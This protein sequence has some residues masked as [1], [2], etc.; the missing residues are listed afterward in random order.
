[1]SKNFFT[2][3]K[4]LSLKPQLNEP[5]SPI[6]GDSYYD[7]VIKKFRFYQDNKWINL[8][9]GNVEQ[10][11]LYQLLADNGMEEIAFDSFD[12]ESTSIVKSS[13]ILNL[14]Q[15][16]ADG[17]YSLNGGASKNL[18]WD[19]WRLPDSGQAGTV[20]TNNLTNSS[21]ASI[22]SGALKLTDATDGPANYSLDL[23]ALSDLNSGDLFIETE[24]KLDT[25]TAGTTRYSTKTDYSL[26]LFFEDGSNSIQLRFFEDGT[27]RQVGFVDGN[28]SIVNDTRTGNS[29]VYNTDWSQYQTYKLYKRAGLTTLYVNNELALVVNT[30][31]FSSTTNYSFSWGGLSNSDASIS[32]W[33]YIKLNAFTNLL[34]TKVLNYRGT[35]AFEGDGNPTSTSS[36]STIQDSSSGLFLEDLWNQWS[37]TGS[38]TVTTQNAG[39]LNAA[40]RIAQS[41]T[42]NKTYSI[43]NSEYAGLTNMLLE[44]SSVSVQAKVTFNTLSLSNATNNTII[45]PILSLIG[46]NK[47]FRVQFKK[48]TNS[49]SGELHLGYFSSSTEETNKDNSIGTGEGYTIQEKESVVI[50]L[51]RQG[52]DNIQFLINGEIQQEASIEDIP[53]DTTSTPSIKWGGFDNLTAG[54][55]FTADWEFVRLSLNQDFPYLPKAPI[56]EYIASLNLKAHDAYISYSSDSIN[57]T[58]PKKV[59]AVGIAELTSLPIN[60]SSGYPQARIMISAESG[61]QIENAAIMFNALFGSNGLPSQFIKTFTSTELPSAPEDAFITHNLGVASDEIHVFGGADY[62]VPTLDWD[63][64]NSNSIKIYN[65]V[66]G[67]PYTIQRVGFS[68]D[69]SQDN[70]DKINTLTEYSEHVLSSNVTAIGRISELEF[71]NLEI[72]ETYEINLFTLSDNSLLSTAEGQVIVKLF[73]GIGGTELGRAHSIISNSGSGSKALGISSGRIIRKME[74]STL[75]VNAVQIEANLSIFGNGTTLGT[76]INLRKLPNANKTTK[77]D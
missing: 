5:S 25:L 45:Q 18:Y 24:M 70:T 74:N 60:L 29:A 53:A 30:S 72:G 13:S 14:T 68:F 35:I 41:G 17:L 28:S 58:S 27:T 2:I 9:S 52:N 22:T 50:E 12:G 63:Y 66:V 48:T 62:L 36:V 10:A 43:T 65:A 69:R 8:G 64:V 67:V 49:N 26:G 19:G 40:L 15:N 37:A 56:R 38:A 54:D 11:L 71:T 42:N 51:R 55:S 76:R 47:T 1:M 39:K 32:Y 73:D 57:W 34:E 7:S 61:A 44:G 46:S 77:W 21:T 33:K 4:G 23:S 16:A 3:N 6:P 75:E 59:D 20:Y 31:D